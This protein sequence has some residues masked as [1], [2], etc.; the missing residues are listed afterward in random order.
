MNTI[1][2][3]AKAE[4]AP[5]SDDDLSYATKVTARVTPESRPPAGD[6]HVTEQGNDGSG[7]PGDETPARAEA[8]Q[9]RRPDQPEGEPQA[10]DHD[11]KGD[12]EDRRGGEDRQKGEPDGKASQKPD[13]DAKQE[14]DADKKD[15]PPP[16]PPSKWVFIVVGL[17]LLALLGWGA[18]KHWSRN[19]A[20]GDTNQKAAAQV[21]EVR[22]TEAKLLD[23]PVSLTLPGQTESFLTANIYPRA[24]G[25]VTERN[26]DIGSR[27]EKGQL[28][29]HIQAPDLDQQLAQAVAQLGQV[30]A[31]EL[32][33]QA[34]VNQAEANLNLAKVTLARTN[35]LTQQGYET[36]QN[37]DNQQANLSSQEAALATAK[38]GIKVADANT[39]A[40][41]ATIDRLK[42]LAAFEDVRAPFDGVV[43]AR[44]VEVG[45]LL[46][47]DSA[48]SSTPLFS[49]DRD[50]VIRVTVQVP[51]SSAIGVRD[52]LEAKVEVP[53]MPGESFTG[54][55]ARSSVALLSSARTLTTEVDIP[56][57][58]RRL[59]SGLYVYVSFAVPR[60]HPD[61]VVPAE[62][63]IFN[64]N[65]LKVATVEDD[66]IKLHDVKIYRDFGTSVELSEGLKGGERVV[67]SPPS[68]LREDTK[69]SPKNADDKQ[70]PNG[71]QAPA[72]KPED[73]GQ[74]NQAEKPK[75]SDQG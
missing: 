60:V 18:Y 68:M 36:L 33:A 61:V 47:A 38:A 41:Q 25:Y 50:D 4:A 29:V 58:D 70:K 21:P 43:T 1:V 44:N 6:D 15:E 16:P 67:L 5:P 64:Q 11:R 37:R 31:A 66:K 40:Q 3:P 48:A 51:Q 8:P 59:R 53:Q 2:A 63:L 30:Q 7:T 57:P 17:I 55:V 13:D 12:T 34:Q 71:N 32:Q 73:K 26:V 42:A 56:N 72:D 46:N 45:N 20:A 65:G 69:V 62:S 35:S 28:L 22:T 14:Q 23:T 54:K 49:I 52:G 39:R 9:A 75:G 24:T 27:V 19:E 74:E 10:A